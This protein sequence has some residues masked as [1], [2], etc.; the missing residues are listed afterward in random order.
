MIIFA[1][2]NLIQ[3]EN[4]IKIGIYLF[5]IHYIYLIDNVIDSLAS[6]LITLIC[7]SWFSQYVCKTIHYRLFLQVPLPRV[8]AWL[9]AAYIH[10]SS[11]IIRHSLC[12]PFRGFIMGLARPICC[13]I[14]MYLFIPITLRSRMNVNAIHSVIHEIASK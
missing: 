9:G 12:T 2:F 10:H 13:D 6:S 5:I 11:F 1:N 3:S 8:G 4:I 7:F 14:C